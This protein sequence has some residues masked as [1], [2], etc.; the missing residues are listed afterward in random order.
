MLMVHQHTYLNKAP[1]HLKLKEKNRKVS[2]EEMMEFE[3][4]LGIPDNN[5]AEVISR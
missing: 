1:T 4:D 5:K 2:E 3:S